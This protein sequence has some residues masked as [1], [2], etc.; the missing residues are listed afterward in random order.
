MRRSILLVAALVTAV[1]AVA[2]LLGAGGPAGLP[3]PGE[4]ITGQDL[5]FRVE[6]VGS[7]RVVGRFVVRVNGE[8]MEAAPPAPPMVIPAKP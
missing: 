2:L 7:D 6:A 8:W 1:S 4:V 3:K 5:G